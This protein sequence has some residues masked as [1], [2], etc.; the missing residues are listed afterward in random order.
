MTDEPIKIEK[1]A[2]RRTVIVKKSESSTDIST[3]SKEVLEV[4]LRSLRDRANNG[5]LD[6]DEVRSLCAT[7]EALLKL[8]K[9][10]R[11]NADQFTKLSDTEL[12]KLAHEALDTL[13][14]KQ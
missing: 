3:M 12:I 13:E 5:T 11:E 8:N 14:Y 1:R 9:E 4:T 6:F 10:A 7:V 2:P